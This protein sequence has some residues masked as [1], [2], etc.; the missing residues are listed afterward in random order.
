MAAEP[1]EVLTDEPALAVAA[2]KPV[3]Y[4]FVIFDLLTSQERWDEHPILE[5]IEAQRF[6]LV[7][8]TTPLDAPPEQERWSPS[9]TAALKSSY[10]SAG[11][12]EGYW[13]Y[14][15]TGPS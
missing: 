2:G 12:Q 6:A 14:R 10:T 5:A 3:L 4:E 1:G 7:I 11:Y 8:L 13:L 15:P 9:L